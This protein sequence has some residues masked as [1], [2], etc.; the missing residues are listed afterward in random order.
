MTE[1]THFAGRG[2]KSA[3]ETGT[4]LSPK[5][6]RDGLIPCIATD[7][8]TGEVLMFAYMNETSLA[9]TIETGIAH[10]WSRSRQELWKKGETS[11]NLQRIVE[12][13]TDCDQDVVWI[14]VRVDGAGASCHVGYKSCFYRRIPVGVPATPDLALEFAEDAPLFDPK[15]VY[16]K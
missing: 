6:D 12:A 5:F 11:G 14:R 1:T 3:L 7:A 9:L 13:R 2:D 8:D 10:Y 16:G 15:D 4:A